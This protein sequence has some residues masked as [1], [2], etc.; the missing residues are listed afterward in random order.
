MKNRNL[1]LTSI[2]GALTVILGAFGSHVLKEKLGAEGL[3]TFE[4]AVKYQMYHVIVLLVVN[5]MIQLS[6]KS[7]NNISL[8]F[9]L[10]ILFFSGSLYLITIF[11]VNPKNIWFVTPLGGLFFILGWLRLLYYLFKGK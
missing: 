4:T 2:L 6:I 10:G 1:I 5:S 8:F 9:F 11:G 3:E 7:K